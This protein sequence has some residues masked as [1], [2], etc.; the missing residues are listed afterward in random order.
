MVEG[1]CGYRVIYLF[2]AAH[3]QGT[4]F[5]E[6]NNKLYRTPLYVYICLNE[7]L[8]CTLFGFI[9]VHVYSVFALT[10]S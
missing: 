9:V 3:T 4:Q 10:C 6:R 8:L 1:R 5:V 2:K 7:I